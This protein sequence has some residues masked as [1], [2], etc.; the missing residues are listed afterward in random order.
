MKIVS[1]T[2]IGP[3]YPNVYC[4]NGEDRNDAEPFSCGSL[5]YTFNNTVENGKYVFFFRINLVLSR[6]HG[7]S[8][9]YLLRF[10]SYGGVCNG[11]FQEIYWS[12]RND[13]DYTVCP[14]EF[15]CNEKEECD[16]T[17]SNI[18][19]DAPL[20]YKEGCAPYCGHCKHGYECTQ[21]GNCVKEGQQAEKDATKSLDEL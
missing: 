20:N 19:S 11:I 17:N 5:E 4:L 14:N 12:F 10:K 21:S 7:F 2:P 3:S 15:K 13:L 9:L 1:N 8:N 6:C 18:V 16:S